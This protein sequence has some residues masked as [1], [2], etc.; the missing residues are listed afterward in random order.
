[1]DRLVVSADRKRKV[2]LAI[3]TDVSLPV[4]GS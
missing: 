2:P 3:A 1:M 4:K